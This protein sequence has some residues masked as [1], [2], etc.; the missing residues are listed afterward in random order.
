MTKTFRLLALAVA[1]TV[2]LS[3]CG[4]LNALIPDQTIDGG[5]LG[6]GGGVD[7]TLRA[8]G[9]APTAIAP[10]AGADAAVWVG[11]IVG[12]TTI[13]AIA[14]LPEFVEA[15][16]ITETIALGDTVVVTHPL[17]PTGSFTVT[18]LALGGTI[19]IGGTQFA[20]PA[21]IAV[22]GLSV[23]F[24]D[25]DCVA[26]GDD[27]V[28]TYVT[29]SGVPELEVQFAANQVAAFS[30]LIKGIGGDVDVDLTVTVTLAEPGLPDDASVR[31]TLESLDAVIEF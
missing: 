21:G 9:V 25:P 1:S 2:V 10:S 16:D 26:S 7:V 30:E 23:V 18:G 31:V 6:A 4:A 15:A 20:L 12:S 17:T 13:E 29:A 3:A 5:I 8:D 19:T 22:T 11:P 24:A 14:E 27:Q 28:C